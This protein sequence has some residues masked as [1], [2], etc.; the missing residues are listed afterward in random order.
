MDCGSSSTVLYIVIQVK[1]IDNT[2]TV[3][4]Y[5]DLLLGRFF[6]C[7]STELTIINSHISAILSDKL[8]L[9]KRAYWCVLTVSVISTVHLKLG[10]LSKS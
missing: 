5:T 3:I 7:L 10:S 6:H 1:Y 8:Y 2:P 9:Y 4:P